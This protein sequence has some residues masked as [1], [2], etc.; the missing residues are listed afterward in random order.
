M[1]TIEIS[2]LTA[3]GDLGDNDLFVL[4]QGGEAKKITASAMLE[5]IGTALD[6]HGGINNISLTSSVGYVNT[7]TITYA[8]T[9][10]STFQVTN[11]TNGTNGVGIS[12]I[13]INPSTCA[14]TIILSNGRSYTTPSLKGESGETQY[15]GSHTVSAVGVATSTTSITVPIPWRS[16]DGEAPT[17]SDITGVSVDGLESVTAALDSTR[18]SK[19]TI[20]F[21]LT[22]TSLTVGRAYLCQIGF[23][24]S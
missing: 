18:T 19:D 3:A 20:A 12:T 1:A 15:F 13:Q 7:Y 8:D 17:V 16:P 2:A 4:S 22:S 14:L 10:T 5:Q 23:T 9:T 6:G 11:G 24:L 21:E